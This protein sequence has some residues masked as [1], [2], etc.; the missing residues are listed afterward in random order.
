MTPIEGAALTDLDSCPYPIPM[1]NE[2]VMV[3]HLENKEPRGT[4]EDAVDVGRPPVAVQREVVIGG[5]IVIQSRRA[6][7]IT[8]N[9]LTLHP[10]TV[11]HV[12]GAVLGHDE[13]G[14]R[15]GDHAGPDNENACHGDADS[16]ERQSESERCQADRETPVRLPLQ[17]IG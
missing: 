13:T 17:M 14:D 10:V 8:Q 5:V 15:Q 9:P 16:Q 1:E 11:G 7:P 12:S 3:L 4:H 2:A 6:E